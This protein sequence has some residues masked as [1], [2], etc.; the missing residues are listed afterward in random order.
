MTQVKA[1]AAKIASKAP[2]AVSASKR[3]LRRA[4]E[5]SLRAGNELE[6]E[7]FA[8][9]FATADQKEG[10][11]AFVEKRAAVWQSR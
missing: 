6:R 5:L 10:T 1:Q 9:L 4:E 11:R 2:L 3:A 8:A 7:L